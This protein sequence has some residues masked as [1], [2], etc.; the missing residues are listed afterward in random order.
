MSHNKLRTLLIL[1]TFITLIIAAIA[2]LTNA[3]EWPDEI[4]LTTQQDFDGIPS[5]AQ[6]NDGRIWVVWCSKKGLESGYEI[7]YSIYNGTSWSSEETLTTDPD[8]DNCPSIS[9]STD[10]TIWIVWQSQRSNNTD[11]FYKISSDNGETWSDSI[12]LTTFLGFD[13]N[14]QVFQ[15]KNGTVWLLWCSSRM[16]SE[17]IFYMTTSDNGLHWSN[18]TQLTT[19]PASDKFPSITQAHNGS[20]WVAF[21][22]DRADLGYSRI[23]YTI[24][25]GTA[26]SNAMEIT[27]EERQLDTDPSIVQTKQGAI[28]VFWSSRKATPTAKD[29]LFYKYTY[30]NGATW[31]ENIQLPMITDKYD[32]MWSSV[33]QAKDR[34]IWVVWTTTRFDQ[35][36]GNFDIMY[37]TTNVVEG[38][39]NGDGTV[40][41]MDLA[42]VGKSYGKREGESGYSPAPDLNNDDWIWVADLATVGKHYGESI[43]C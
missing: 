2:P 10:G 9:Q 39:V 19:D 40:N 22:S 3:C 1:A 35:P 5:V 33:T 16:G 20:L 8:V 28:Y 38:D 30:D 24:Y 41:I 37:K 23:Y 26:W 12:Q 42:S 21:S 31:S 7:V 4:R 14:P 29:D 32:D 13:K 34:K 15:A 11:I 17:D 6:M 43:D 25:N 18:V 27:T 36:D